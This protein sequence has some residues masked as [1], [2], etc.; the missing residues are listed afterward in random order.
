[1]RENI[2]N[3]PIQVQ[4]VQGYPVPFEQFLKDFQ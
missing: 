3:T 1:M 2:E 4:K